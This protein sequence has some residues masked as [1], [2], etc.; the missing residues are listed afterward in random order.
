MGH[1]LGGCFDPE[2][3]QLLRTVLDEAWDALS[4]SRKQRCS[5]PNLQNAFLHQ[6]RSATRS[7]TAPSHCADAADYYEPS[8]G[9]LQS[10]L[11]R[12]A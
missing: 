6:R 2:T 11:A 5:R 4:P 10:S 8:G 3:I 7:R 9:H 12:N 1:Q